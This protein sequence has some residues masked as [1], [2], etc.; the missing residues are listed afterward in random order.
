MDEKENKDL[1]ESQAKLNN[2]LAEKAL[3]EAEAIRAHTNK[4]TSN[5]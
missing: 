5:D 1:I 3:A 4:E 2:A